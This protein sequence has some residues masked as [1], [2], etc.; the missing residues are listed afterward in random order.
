MGFKGGIVASLHVKNLGLTQGD[1]KLQISEFSIECGKFLGVLGSSGAGKSTLLHAI[2]G[3]NKSGGQIWLDDKPLHKIEPHLRQIGMVFQSPVLMEDW[4]VDENL[5]LLLRAKKAPKSSWDERIQKALQSTQ[6]FHLL[7]AKTSRLSGGERQRV[8]IAQAL[9]FEPKVLLM[10]EPF[11]ALDPTLRRGLGEMIRSLAREKNIA[12]VFVT[13]DRDE[14]FGLCDTLIVLE[15]GKILQIGSPKEL[16]ESPKS[17]LVAKYME[18]D[19]IVK[20]EIGANDIFGVKIDDLKTPCHV[21]VPPRAIIPS[22]LG[23]LWSVEEVHYVDGRFLVRFTNGLRTFWPK[24]PESKA[25]VGL[26]FCALRFLG[27]EDE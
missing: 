8:G 11:S 3:L 18:P 10:D 14:A 24:E 22:D 7:N 17:V 9:L 12:V 4:S 26:D 27:E 21:Y 20:L 13:H 19:G 5:R 16:Y 1:F 15:R 25:R 6:I 2:A 23:I